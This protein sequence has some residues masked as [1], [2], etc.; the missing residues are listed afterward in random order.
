M[1]R[2]KHTPDG[3]YAKAVEHLRLLAMEGVRP[4]RPCHAARVRELAQ[5]PRVAKVVGKKARGSGQEPLAT[6]ARTSSVAMPS[7][8]IARRRRPG[9]SSM[10][11]KSTRSPTAWKR[12]IAL[13]RSNAM[14]YARRG[15][16]RRVPGRAI[17]PECGRGRNM[18]RATSP[19]DMPVSPA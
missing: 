7:A 13:W 12:S 11:Q 4:L 17:P 14:P 8:P 15:H 6:T 19:G 10:V 3:D 9:G 1:G 5:S 16:L 18:R 2:I